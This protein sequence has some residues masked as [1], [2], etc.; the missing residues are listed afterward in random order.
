LRPEYY[1]VRSQ[2]ALNAYLERADIRPLTELARS[3]AEELPD[4]KAK[5]AADLFLCG[6]VERDRAVTMG[7]LAAMPTEGVQDSASNQFLPREWFAGLA[8][9]V[10][11]DKATAQTAFA[12]ARS[13]LSKIVQDQ[14]DYAEA[15]SYLGLI[16][17][18]LG[19]KDDAVTEGRRACELRP[20][21]ADALNGIL[22]L[23][24]LAQIYAWTGE[25]DQA[26][27]QLRLA[28]R[29]PFGINY[30]EL[31]L[32]P[33]WDPLRADARFEQIVAS[34]APK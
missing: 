27:E 13:V 12:S 29:L 8:A 19:R 3:G 22:L 23:Q 2:L 25:K 21:A 33:A 17:A 16:D 24:N 32:H 30:G 6:L 7:A 9:C 34:L 5:T 28:A 20:V 11:R 31:K 14:P 15:W 18:G 10:F 4:W 1:F 26:L